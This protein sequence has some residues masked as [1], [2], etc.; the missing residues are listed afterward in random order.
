VGAEGRLEN[1][2]LS[3][4]RPQAARECCLGCTRAKNFLQSVII[5]DCDN[6]KLT[7]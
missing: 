7:R 2:F 3:R 4:E 1:I 5:I 6:P